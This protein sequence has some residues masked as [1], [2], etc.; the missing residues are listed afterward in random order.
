MLEAEGLK[1]DAATIENYLDG[2]LDA[3]VMHR[4]SRYD[5][6]GKQLSDKSTRNRELKALD[7]IKDHNPK[8]LL[9]MDKFFT[10]EHKGIRVLN[11]LDW[12]G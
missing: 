6:K 1:M 4:A 11:V 3:F 7:A 8:F 5:I 12:L 10:E 2:L 9:T